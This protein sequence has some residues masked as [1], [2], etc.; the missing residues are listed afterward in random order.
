MDKNDFYG[1]DFAGFN[2]ETV[3]KWAMRDTR[4]ESKTFDVASRAAE[5]LG[6][7]MS[8]LDVLELQAKDLYVVHAPKP[9]S[10][11]ETATLEEATESLADRATTLALS[12]LKLEMAMTEA[13]RFNIDLECRLLFASGRSVDALIGLGVAH[14]LEFASV[15]RLFYEDIEVPTSKTDLFKSRRLSPTEKRKLMRVMQSALD[16]MLDSDVATLNE[17]ELTSSRALKRPQNKRASDTL[18][19]DRPFVDVLV[20]DYELSKSMAHLVCRA[21]A[22][23]RPDAPASE[24]LQGLYRHLRSLGTHVGV[25]TALLAPIYGAAEIPQALCRASAVCGGVY[26]LRRAPL[27]LILSDNAVI[28]AVFADGAVI[29]CNKAVVSCDYLIDAPTVGRR[30]RRISL[31]ESDD[32]NSQEPTVRVYDSGLRLATLGPS[33]NAVP[34]DSL[35]LMHAVADSLDDFE[36]IATPRSELWSLLYSFPVHASFMPSADAANLAAVPR[37]PSAPHLDI[38]DE[39]ELAERLFQR[40]KP[41]SPFLLTD[42]GLDEGRRIPTFVDEDDEDLTEIVGKLEDTATQSTRQ[43]D[44]LSPPLLTNDEGHTNVDNVRGQ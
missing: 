7:D 33:V 24:G 3:A 15:S 29:R 36:R 35:R 17:R 28:A 38:F 2:L 16:V 11:P 21:L 22:F 30:Y 6:V 42:D 37:L 9:E 41:G 34:N 1:A 32:D 10:A 4:L 40:I 14:Y 18:S 12:E 31:V 5:A 26:A 27:A 39:V 8:S 20:A 25:S 44:Q 13:K 43:D 23:V 19:L